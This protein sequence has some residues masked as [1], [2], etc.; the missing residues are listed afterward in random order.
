MKNTA[1]KNP[2]YPT[3]LPFKIYINFNCLHSVSINHICTANVESI[4]KKRRKNHRRFYHHTFCNFKTDL[5][6]EQFF[7][8][9]S[10]VS[11]KQA[12]FSFFYRLSSRLGFHSF[13]HWLH[14]NIDFLWHFRNERK[15]HIINT[16]FAFYTNLTHHQICILLTFSTETMIV[17]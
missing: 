5:F 12:K 6:G 10:L 14:I 4:L 17:A 3:A 2:F 1:T 13:Y 11:S 16:Q 15:R 9:L 8:S 7:M